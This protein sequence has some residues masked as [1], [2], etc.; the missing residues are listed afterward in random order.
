MESVFRIMAGC[1]VALVSDGNKG[2]REFGYRIHN[3]IRESRT[4]RGESDPGPRIGDRCG[5]VD[6]SAQ[7][8]GTELFK[9]TLMEPADGWG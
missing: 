6:S 4:F 5:S 7:D 9:P 1:V 2:T 8:A 3:K